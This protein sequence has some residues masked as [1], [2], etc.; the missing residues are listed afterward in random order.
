MYSAPLS[1]GKEWNQDKKIAKKGEMKYLAK[2]AG[3]GYTQLHRA[4]AQP[5]NKHTL[6]LLREWIVK[7]LPHVVKLRTTR[8]RQSEKIITNLPGWC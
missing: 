8:K 2:Y 5:H 1:A 3:I 7:T 4:K 6:K